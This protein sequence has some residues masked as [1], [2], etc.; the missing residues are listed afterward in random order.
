MGL[1]G[2]GIGPGPHHMTHNADVNPSLGKNQPGHHLNGSSGDAA[3]NRGGI[4][5]LTAGLMPWPATSYG[6][7][8]GVGGGVGGGLPGVM[9]GPGMGVGRGGGRMERGV[10]SDA[11]QHLHNRPPLPP[12]PPPTATTSA[13]AGITSMQGTGPSTNNLG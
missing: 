12:L 9:G 5:P 6:I 11:L 13:G 7:G 3:M 10:T 1:G 4:V 8:G 2:L